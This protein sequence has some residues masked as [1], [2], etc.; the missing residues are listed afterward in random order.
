MIEPARANGARWEKLWFEKI[1]TRVGVPPASR[2]A[3]CAAQW[4]SGAGVWGLHF[5]RHMVK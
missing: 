4:G 1:H 2:H 5:A 3:S